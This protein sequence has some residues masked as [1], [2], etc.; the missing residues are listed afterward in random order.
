MVRNLIKS[1]IQDGWFK[2]DFENQNIFKEYNTKGT[3]II[4]V[5]YNNTGSTRNIRFNVQDQS[6]GLIKTCY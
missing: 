1:N 6:G 2:P 5:M 4:R 3:S